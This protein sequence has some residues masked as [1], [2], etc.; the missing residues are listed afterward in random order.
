MKPLRDIR[1][2]DLSKVIAGP[3]CAQ[4]LGDF[5]AEV[6]K[7]EPISR[8]DDTRGWPPHKGGE[9]AM[10]LSI[11]RNKRGI[12]LDLKS[13]EG[14]AIVHE[15][16]ARS[17]VVIQGFGTGTAA[18]LG[19]DA[20]TLRKLNDRMIYCE[21]SGFGRNGPMGDRPGYDVML[22]A[23]SGMLSTLGHPDGDLVRASFSPID[24]ATAAHATSGILAALLERTRTG[25]GAYLEVS[26]M[27][28]ALS[29]MQYMAQGYWQTGQLPRRM[30]SG[31]EVLTPYQAFRAADGHVMIAVGNDDQWR[32]FCDVAGLAEVRDDPRFATNVARVANF[33]ETVRIVQDQVGRRT[34]ADWIEILTGAKV[35]CSPVHTIDQALAHPQVAAR[36][37]IVPVEH[38]TVGHMNVVAHPVLFEGASRVPDRPAP[39]HGQHTAEILRGLGRSEDAIADLARRG[40]VH[41]PPPAEPGS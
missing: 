3:L 19:V 39:L 24:Q 35:P 41:M 14:R 31:H 36:N 22:Q 28:T 25:Q 13:A 37:V 15:L 7:V 17:D 33:A 29:F 38:P 4:S 16:A 2:L 10:F 9:S 5:G 27:E 23:F 8:G 30:G 11:N 12:A 18:R 32:R 1:V 21:I 34:V 6:V 26:L 20:P 40:V